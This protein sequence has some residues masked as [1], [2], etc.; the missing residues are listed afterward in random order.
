VKKV[1][2]VVSTILLASIIAVASAWVYE[3]S[4][5]NVTQTVKDI[6]SLTLQNAALGDIEE[7][8][9]KSITKAT[10][11]S[12]GNIVSTTTTKDNVY[13]HFNS[14]ADA[15]TS[16][17]SA[18]TITVKYVAVGAGSSH[19]VGDVACTMTIASPDPAT[20]TLDKAGTWTFDFEVSMTAKSVS[21]D[22]ATTTTIVVSAESS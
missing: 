10:Q 4:Q 8:E 16:A 2:A 1:S 7:G 17:F 18:Y 20:V 13:L 5:N 14:D 19:N 11:A 22:Q 21:S 6:A 12:L 15:L 3:M 9:T